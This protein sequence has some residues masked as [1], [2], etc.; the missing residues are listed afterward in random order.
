MKLTSRVIISLALLL[1]GQGAFAQPGD[2]DKELK[3]QVNEA[4]MQVYNEQLEQEPNDYNTLFARANQYYFNGNNLK[5]LDDVSAALDLIPAKEK[6]LRFDALML[7]AKI[8]DAR[9]NYEGELADLKEASAIT[10]SSLSCIDML[11]KVSYNLGDYDASEKNYQTILRE[12]P[13]NYDALYGLA[14]IE[15][16]RNNYEKAASYVDKAVNLFTAEPQ[17]YINRADVLNMMEQYEPAAQDLIS[18]LSVGSSETDALRALT[19]MSNKHYEA[20]MEALG[21]S[22]NKAPRVGMF[23]YIRSQIAM[24]HFH[25]AQ[26]LK[27]LKSIINNNLY[28]YSGIY[29]GAA[30][31]QFELMQYGEAL[32]NI[33]KALKMDAK[34]IDYYILKADIVRYN[35]DGG[36]YDDADAV[37]DLAA[38]LNPDY[39][40]MLLAKAHLLIAQRKNEDAVRTINAIVMNDASNAEALLLRGWVYKYRMQKADLAKS[41]FEKMLLNGEGL[42]SLRGFAL[43]ELGR[44]DEARAWAKE[45]INANAAPGGEAYYYAAALLSDMDD[46]DKAYK[47]LESGLAYGFGSAFELKV[48]EDPYVNLKLVRRHP[49]FGKLVDQY[50]SNFVEQ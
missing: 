18:A 43:H 35:G 32:A 10:P 23:Y 30:K 33:N 7:R 48:N 21:N 50:G 49:D 8:Y 28:D 2:D 4:V 44:A 1:C 27:D 25:Y 39:A 42:T 16:K 26:A 13:T 31:C 3:Q 47:Y 12:N 45:I 5:A 38:N 9:Q 11:A 36:N 14:K 37:L 6:E 46:N 22:I 29:Y 24:S 19:E 34:E 17:V 20:V 40:P 15:V 41:D